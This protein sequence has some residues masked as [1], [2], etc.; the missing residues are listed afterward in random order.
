MKNKDFY[1]QILKVIITHSA[2]GQMMVVKAK[3]KETQKETAILCANIIN[4][5]GQQE[6]LPIALI[7]DDVYSRYTPLAQDPEVVLAQSLAVHVDVVTVVSPNK[8]NLN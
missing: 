8:K 7:E 2:A 5:D 1:Q 3:N 4:E 6:V